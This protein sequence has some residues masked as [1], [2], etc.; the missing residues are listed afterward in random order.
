MDSKA[1]VLMPRL[2]HSRLHLCAGRAEEMGLGKSPVLSVCLEKEHIDG[3]AEQKSRFVRP[4]KERESFNYHS[5]D[6]RS[7]M[8]ASLYGLQKCLD[9][10]WRSWGS[11]P[12]HT[13]SA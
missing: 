9:T 6:F 8:R 3:S 10:C 5:Q 4:T 1:R 7:S 12:S 2:P 11:S 13:L